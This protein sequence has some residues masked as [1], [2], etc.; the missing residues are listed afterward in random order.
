MTPSRRSQQHRLL[1][2]VSTPAVALGTLTLASAFALGAFDHRASPVAAACR[3]PA[4]VDI[5]SFTVAVLNGSGI[6]GQAKSTAEQL[7]KAGFRVDTVATASDGRWTDAPAVIS[8][9]A[10]GRE[11]ALLLA[12]H[13]PGAVQVPTLALDR[14]LEVVLGTAFPGVS[15]TP[16]ASQPACDA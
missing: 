6:P 5:A 8:Y 13:L 9:G 2:F 1:V 10:R 16:K 4:Q 15:L 11:P 7:T 12:A 14:D 3:P